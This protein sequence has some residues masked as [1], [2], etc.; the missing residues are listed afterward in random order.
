V[1][2]ERGIKERGEK[3]EREDGGWLTVGLLHAKES[4]WRPQA[5]PSALGFAWGAGGIFF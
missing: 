4:C 1:E 3:E 2:E 5:E